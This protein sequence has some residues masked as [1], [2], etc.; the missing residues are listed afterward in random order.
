MKYVIL[1]CDGMADNPIESLGGRTPM[2]AAHN[3]SMNWLAQTATV[4]MVRTVPE[5]M[6]PGSDVAN[7]SVLGYDP[8]KVYTGRSPLEAASM[9]VELSE[10]DMAMRCNLVTLSGEGAFEDKT[11]ADYC[12]GDIS[13]GEAAQ[14]IAALQQALGGNGL[15]F[16]TGVSYRHCLVSRGGW[17]DYGV[18]TPP[19]DISGKRIG[20]Y[21]NPNPA[22]KPYIDMMRRSMGVLER[23]PVNLARMERGEKPA[24]AIWFWGQG[25]RPALTN[26]EEK[27]GLKGSMVSAVDLLKGIARCAGM[28][29]V[30]VEGATG[31]I[32]TN[33]Y[34]K[35]VAAAK[36]LKDGQDFVYIHI[37]APDECGHR[38]EVETKVRS[39]EMIDQFVLKPLLNELEEYDDYRILVLPD[40]P[41]PLYTRTHSGDPVPFLLYQKTHPCL[42]V[43][44][45]SEEQAR[46]TGVF[47]AQGH[48]LIERLILR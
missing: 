31:Y 3:P 9:G 1:L 38:G 37:E 19:H 7:L 11:M 39:I 47:V 45:F 8:A 36:E 2:E 23:H 12:A 46:K 33:F 6:T 4:G 22:A 15:E 17:G 10:Q 35:A 20:D 41:T 28:R 24:N 32:D 27:T 34:G 30:E 21:L 42:G 5:G 16:H 29:V 40:H 26:F 14:L 43:P 13:T 25:S 48:T 44:D 18:F